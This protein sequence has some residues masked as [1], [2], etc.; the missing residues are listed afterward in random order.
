MK[1][2]SVDELLG[3]TISLIGHEPVA[4]DLLTPLTTLY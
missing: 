1:N 2:Y 3:D 4:P